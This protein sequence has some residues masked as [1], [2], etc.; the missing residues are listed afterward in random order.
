MGT[1]NQSVFR[2]ETI[3][4]RKNGAIIQH[5]N[6]C[7]VF[8]H[9]SRIVSPYCN[10]L[11][12]K[13]TMVPCNFD[14]ESVR[15]SFVRICYREYYLHWIIVEISF[16]TI[17]V[18]DIFRFRTKNRMLFPLLDNMSNPA[19]NTAHRKSRGKQ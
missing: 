7:A 19:D 16:L 18:P 8:L 3:I 6:C 9:E 12:S 13:S 15:P 17:I 4:R 1:I 2:L 14:I 11:H 5:M 10:P